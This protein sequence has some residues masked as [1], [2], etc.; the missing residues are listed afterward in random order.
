MQ[1]KSQLRIMQINDYIM[2][3]YS[4]P[5]SL[6]TLSDDLYLSEGYLSR[7][8]KKH[9][10]MS[11][12]TYLRQ[13]RLANAM[14]ELMYTDKPILEI[15]LD[16]GFSS[17]SFFN[18]VF[19]D[20]Y[21]QTPSNARSQAKGEKRE[22]PAFESV[23]L[24][25]KLEQFLYSVEDKEDRKKRIRVANQTFKI[26]DGKPVA[27]FFN[28]AIN[29]GEASDLLNHEIRKQL[30]QLKDSM[31]FQYV[32]FWSL[33]SSKV[34]MKKDAAVD[35]YNFNNLDNIL[36]FLVGNGLKPFFNMEEKI[37]RVNKTHKD[38]LVFEER[39][40]QVPSLSYWEDFIR[41]LITHLIRRYGLEEVNTWKMEVFFDGYRL[42]ALEPVDSFFQIF[43]CS[44]SI[45]KKICP[46]LRGGRLRLFPGLSVPY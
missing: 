30:I 13:I 16:N 6:K 36:D 3:H 43:K 24:N 39:E 12:T 32:R 22:E 15:A 4:Q 42:E 2:N 44:Y 8:F 19:K 35:Y 14:N 23:V 34:L 27:Q 7:F 10:H 45:I 26:T 17:V 37:R 46:D 5:I 21:G 28:T 33:F 25:E 40:K 29:I 38:F 31:R 18:R 1:Q 41:Q 20:E 9:Y 11:F